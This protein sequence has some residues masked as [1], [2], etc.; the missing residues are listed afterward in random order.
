MREIS[1]IK[2]QEKNNRIAKF[3]CILYL[4]SILF[5]IHNQMIDAMNAKYSNK[6][7]N[8]KTPAV[9]RMTNCTQVITQNVVKKVVKKEYNV[10]NVPDFKSWTNFRDSVSRNSKQWDILTGKNTYTDKYGFR[11]LN[12]DYMC[13]MGSY[14]VDKLGDRFEITTVDNN[15]FTVTICDIK[16]DNHTDRLNQYTLSNNCIVEFYVDDNLTSSV[17]FNG[18]ASSISCLSGRIS[19]IKKIIYSDANHQIAK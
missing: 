9:Q 4:I 17:K 12:D 14:Y 18:S 6:T 7:Y 5:F 8:N 10:P 3:I 16:S 15:T 2:Y 19:S 11:R 13:A 1:N